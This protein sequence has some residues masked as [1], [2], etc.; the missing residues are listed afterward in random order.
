MSKLKI[1]P[2]CCGRFLQA[3]KSNFTYGTDPGKKIISPIL[4]WYIE[5]ARH[6]ILVDTGLSDPE[7]AARYH[8]PLLQT[9][10]EQ[11]VNAVKSLGLAP[12]DIEIIVNTH[13][14]WDHS[15]NNHLFPNARIL[16][17]EEELRY[18]IAPLPCHAVYYES[19][20]IGL[21]PSWLKSLQRM[22]IISGEKEIEP[23]I[24]LIPLPG[25]TPGFQG[26]L[27]DLDRRR[28]LIAGDT[29]PLWENWEGN[30]QGFRIPP[31]IHVNLRECY[32]TFRKMESIADLVLPGHDIRV[33]EQQVYE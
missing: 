9:A 18:A 1:R 7:W 32:A 15:F 33:L 4:M 5:G 20:S 10:A 6:R 2:L 29:T 26:V 17:Q 19:Q 31:G 25:H 28:G 12:E 14:H 3:E 21:T 16:V 13:L 24:R 8:H 30:A 11:P 23:G 27:V 22:E